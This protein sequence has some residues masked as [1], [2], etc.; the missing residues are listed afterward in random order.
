MSRDDRFVATHQK[1]RALWERAI[2]V[3]RGF[4]TDPIVTR[5]FSIYITHAK[6]SRKWDVDGN[7]YIDYLMGFGA[8]LLGHAHPAMVEAVQ[9]QIVKGTHYGGENEL[10][11]E[12]AERIC[13]LIPC[14]EKIEFILSGSEA[15]ML[16]ARLAR[17]YT[18]R[19]KILKFAE[20]YFGWAEDVLAG[21]APPYDKPFAGQIPPF[22]KGVIGGGAV[23]IPCNDEQAMEEAL[24]RRDIAAFFVEGGGANCGRIGMKPEMVKTARELT[25]KYGTL[26]VIDEVISGFR[27][28]KG[29]YQA[30]IGVTPDLSPLAKLNGG[31]IPGG[32]AVC[33]RADIMDLLQLRPGDAEW[34]RFKHV[35]HRG[36]WNGN[37]LTA[38]AAVEMLKIVE[39]GEVQKIAADKARKLADGIQKEFDKRGIEACCHNATSVLHLHLGK[40]EKCDRTLCLGT[41]KSMP[42]ELVHAWNGHLILNGVHLHR[43]AMGMVSP[44]HTDADIEQTIE[45]FGKAMDGLLEEGVVKSK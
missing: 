33:G 39:K 37:P 6:G 16:I 34:N 20:H 5:P 44:A 13:K 27:W 9:K 43:G 36:T 4:H 2:K 31:G 26:L 8:L 7:E 10:E 32:A 25:R 38:A 14:A 3:S 1:S 41:K 15:D 29:G 23:V 35:I 28:S 24:A 40:C 45:V 18:G 42:A 30:A 12:W 21:I 11:L 22:T 19:S 17:A